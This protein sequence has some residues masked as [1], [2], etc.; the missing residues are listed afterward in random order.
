MEIDGY[1]KIADLGKGGMAFV[2]KSRHIGLDR[3]VALKVM[4]KRLNSDDSFTKRFQREAKI[5]ALL[6]HKHIVQIY[7]VG[8]FQGCNYL[9]MEYV[10]SGDLSDLLE[11][12]KQL[13]EGT[14]VEC[15]KQMA[16]ALDFA[17][18]N[19]IVHRDIKPANILMRGKNDF[20][21]ADFGIAKNDDV[22]SNLTEVGSII[23]TPSYMSP[24]QSKGQTLDHRSD[25]YSLGI[26][27]YQLL[28]NRVP[29]DGD[30]ALSVGIKHISAS[31]PQVIQAYQKYQ[32]I[33]EKLLAKMP[34]DRFQSGLELIS[35][36]N[37]V[38]DTTLVADQTTL[39]SSSP[40]PSTPDSDVLLLKNSR[41]KSYI[42]VFVSLLVLVIT[43]SYFFLLT[44]DLKDAVTPTTP[45]KGE[46]AT[47]TTPTKAAIA[48]PTVSSSTPAIDKSH[49]AQEYNYSFT[50]TNKEALQK[51]VLK[52][53][54]EMI[55]INAGEYS[56]GAN[57]AGLI[58]AR[59]M[60]LVD[61]KR[62][63][64]SKYPVSEA[65]Y[66]LFLTAI[67][68]N[69]N[70]NSAKPLT[71]ISWEG[72][73]E[74]I[75]TINGTLGE[76]FRLPSESEWEYAAS[77]GN[78][79]LYPWG[80]YIG[81]NNAVC[82]NCGSK[83]DNRTSVKVDRFAPNKLGLYSMNGNVWEWVQDCYIDNYE[84][85]PNNNKAREFANCERRV[86]RGGAWNSPKGQIS[87]KYRNASTAIYSS[88][89]MGF[90]L[91]K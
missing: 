79:H 38:N 60:H 16:S 91:A 27:L 88:D 11:Q 18:S 37:L 58:D 33:I 54:T 71:N 39:I 73:V 36:L 82:K 35:A 34:E 42:A 78:K 24:E 9:S 80:K 25:L 40:P 23:G 51:L 13:P 30:S 22:A 89:V 63:K 55:V 4:D 8:I 46:I 17:A 12:H 19:K 45:T 75:N 59:P 29:Y 84:S 74:M 85:G 6:T 41:K 44:D 49:L 31:I 76:N 65:D 66:A 50:I 10:P 1:E 87:S 7:D 86:I 2:Y 90:R 68:K 15:I 43:L 67:G 69:A 48:T 47:P 52:L 72:A 26:V 61:I 28:C 53:N 57:Q 83:W 81:R 64:L 20:V 14:I 77:Y 5:S 3:I 62:F 32:P 21:L 56:M 70:I